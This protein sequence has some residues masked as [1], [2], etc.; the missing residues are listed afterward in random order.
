MR[1]S[2]PI[3]A[4]GSYVGKDGYMRLCRHAPFT[5]TARCVHV[6]GY[7]HPRRR[8]PTSWTGIHIRTDVAI[9]LCDNFSGMLHFL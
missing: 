5:W 6:E 8:A 4:D 3:C 9:Y 7:Y 2:Q 1:T